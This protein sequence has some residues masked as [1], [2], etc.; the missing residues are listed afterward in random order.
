[1][2]FLISQSLSIIETLHAII[3]IGGSMTA[4]SV[5]KLYSLTSAEIKYHTAAVLLRRAVKQ[6]TL[7]RVKRHGQLYYS[8]SPAD[9]EL[10]KTVD[11]F[12]ESASASRTWKVVVFD[13]PETIA[14]RRDM[15]R[16][17]LRRLGFVPLQK[18]VWVTN[19]NVKRADLNIIEDLEITPFV[20]V[21]ETPSIAGWTNLKQLKSSFSLDE[22][23]SRYK[24][25]VDELIA[26]LAR[27]RKGP[28]DQ[29]SKQLAFKC[30]RQVTL[31]KYYRLLQR[32]PELPAGYLPKPWYR[33]R[34]LKLLK[35]TEPLT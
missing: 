24:D 32:D 23:N 6:G 2:S 12:F 20:L 14:V 31:H 18:S 8:L 11:Q 19:R 22:V 1:M 25:L 10:F 7:K 34:L 26:S 27:W 5:C 9:R 4:S 21:F 15:L 30:I 17:K 28:L 3:Y 29:R 16:E 13:I 33:T 35:E